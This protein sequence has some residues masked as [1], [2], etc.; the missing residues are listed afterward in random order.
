MA[1]N[2][3]VPGQ[4]DDLQECYPTLV[5]EPLV[6]TGE[7]QTTLQTT[8]ETEVIT[9]DLPFFLNALIASIGLDSFRPRIIEL[10]YCWLRK[11]SFMGS[12]RCLL[13]KI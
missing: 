1:T 5:L 3:N 13:K 6:A 9:F 11:R 2:T 4:S 8:Q 12:V 10:S 7:D